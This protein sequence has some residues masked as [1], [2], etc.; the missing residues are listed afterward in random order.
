MCAQCQ[1]KNAQ[2][3]RIP[4]AKRRGPHA[5]AIVCYFCYLR[6]LGIRPTRSQQVV[7]QR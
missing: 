6:L 7:P 2:L 5:A 1:Q 3:Y 4:E